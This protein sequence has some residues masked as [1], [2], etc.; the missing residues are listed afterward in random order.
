MWTMPVAALHPGVPNPFRFE[1]QI[2]FDLPQDTSVRLCIYD[3]EGRLVRTLASGPE[4]AGSRSVVWDGRD[5][6]GR[7]VAAGV[8][9]SKL[10]ATGKVLVQKSILLR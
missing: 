7:E 4:S 5:D 2:R 3:V 1:T 8:F 9:F 6:E 10:E